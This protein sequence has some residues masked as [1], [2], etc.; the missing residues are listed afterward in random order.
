MN[1]FYQPDLSYR[2][3]Q[4]FNL[5]REANSGDPLAQHELGIRYLT[6]DGVEADTV[7]A[8]KWIKS[9]ADHGVTAAKYNYAILLINGWGTGW[10]PFSAFE[11]FKKAAEEGMAQAQ[12][13][14]GLLYTDNLIV[15][16]NW[17]KAYNWISKSAQAGNKD[18]RETLK[19]I[20][21]KIPESKIDTSASNLSGTDSTFGNQDGS[22]LKS[23]LGLVYIDFED[24]IDSIPH[25]SNR[26]LLEDLE[27]SGFTVLS[28]SI[29]NSRQDT[30]FV[31]IAG[32]IPLINDAAEYGSPEALVF[33]GR[34]YE[35]GIYYKKDLLRAIE[36]YIRAARLDSQTA[37]IL[38]YQM[39]QAG[40]FFPLIKRESDLDNMV[41]LFD[42]YGLEILGFDHQ[43]TLKDAV[44]LLEKSA[45]KDFPPSLI[46]YGL[47]FYSSGGTGNISKSFSLW[48][49]AADLG[50][51]E[52]EIRINA[53]VVLDQLSNT[54]YK[55]NIRTLLSAS[56]KGSV[57]AQS[58]IAY[59]YEKGI[60]LDQDKA[61]AVRYFRDAAQRGN[62]FAYNRLKALYDSIRPPGSEFKI[63]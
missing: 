21:I 39:Q 22:S 37:A 56:V 57:L 36:Y 48:Q 12:Y 61:K 40:R 14:V 27:H 16:R 47:Y 42:W 1:L 5:I 62:R 55:N 17:G 7:K 4:Q 31:S 6:G 28:D 10:N 60:G 43:I 32:F 24:V 29:R 49:R 52:A 38:L 13:A 41:A 50:S 44:N 15:K 46:E 54:D 45:D 34:L 8:A 23:S 26:R 59:A 35:T 58:A 63:N 3:W 9:A 51:Q 11:Y 53:A 18:A 19:E 33:I 20:Q 30:N 25:V 2:I